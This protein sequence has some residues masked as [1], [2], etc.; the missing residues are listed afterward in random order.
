MRGVVE[1]RTLFIR[2]RNLARTRVLLYRA[3]LIIALHAGTRSLRRFR[4]SI[5][6]S[7]FLSHGLIT[8][9]VPIKQNDLGYLVIA[10]FTSYD[11]L[12]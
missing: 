5:I 8:F 2:T 9:V 4:D 10:I 1:W 3:C 7:C 12:R 6:S 11:I